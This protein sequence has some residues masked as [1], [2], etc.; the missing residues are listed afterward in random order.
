VSA[1]NANVSYSIVSFTTAH[2]TLVSGQLQVQSG[3]NRTIHAVVPPCQIAES[4]SESVNINIVVDQQVSGLSAVLDIQA[5]SS[6]VYNNGNFVETTPLQLTSNTSD[7]NFFASLAIP[8]SASYAQYSVN[9]TLEDVT[10]G[11]SVPFTSYCLRANNCTSPCILQ[12]NTNSQS[13]L[14]LP[15]TPTRGVNYFGSFVV[16]TQSIGQD[17]VRLTTTAK[18]MGSATSATGSTG[19]G[20]TS[21]ASSTRIGL[22]VGFLFLFC[23]FLF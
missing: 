14:S 7:E 6:D 23:I 2:L 19:E 17:S 18:P 1:T 8:T 5:I 15:F 10:T 22:F 9:I 3:Q 16:A 12:G 13:S 21:D 11:S 20:G 4:A